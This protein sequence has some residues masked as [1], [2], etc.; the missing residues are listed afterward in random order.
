MDVADK[1]QVFIPKSRNKNLTYGYKV[2]SGVPRN[3]MI[4][5]RSEGT[6]IDFQLKADVADRLSHRQEMSVP[7]KADIFF[8]RLISRKYFL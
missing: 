5:L 3:I 4:P 6:R 8:E 1:R 7:L 2:L